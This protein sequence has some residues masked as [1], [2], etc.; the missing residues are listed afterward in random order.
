META[1]AA[2]VEQRVV[3]HNVSWQTYERLLAELGE[4]SSLRLTYD[5][6]SL[7]I[8]SPSEEHEELNRALAFLVETLITELDLDARSLGSA[9]FRREDLERG[10]EPDSCFYI[11][12][13][14]RI[15]GKRKLDLSKDPPPDLLIE[16]DLTSSS[17]HKLAIYARLGVPEVW[18]CDKERVRIHK[19]LE[20]G[21]EESLSSLAFPFLTAAKLS[22]FLKAGQTSRRSQWLRSIREWLGS[23]QAGAQPE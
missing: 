1:V 2:A 14:A 16:V 18:R 10:F 6:G 15:K 22:D 7:E 19:L 12:N 21:Y 5:R 8:M 3:L 17:L 9:T 11:Q 23:A 4:C 20:S 13:V